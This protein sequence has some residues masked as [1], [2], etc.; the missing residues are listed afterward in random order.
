MINKLKTNNNNTTCELAK[1]KSVR[2]E[3][4]HSG[5]ENTEKKSLPESN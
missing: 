1:W 4:N 3:F 2:I 5:S